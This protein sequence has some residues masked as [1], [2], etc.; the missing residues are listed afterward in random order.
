MFAP[1]TVIDL[2]VFLVGLLVGYYPGPK[3][4]ND[5]VRQWYYRRTGFFRLWFGWYFNSP[6]SILFVLFSC[7]MGLISTLF[8]YFAVRVGRSYLTNPEIGWFFLLLFGLTVGSTFKQIGWFVYLYRK[9]K[10]ADA[11]VRK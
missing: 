2:I 10:N 3:R 11:A 1:W 5:Y 7:F 8:F 4:Y 9:E 6:L